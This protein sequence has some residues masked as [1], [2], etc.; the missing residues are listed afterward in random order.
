MT[1]VFCCGNDA[2]TAIQGVAKSEKLAVEKS[3]QDFWALIY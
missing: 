2:D 3:C 1:V